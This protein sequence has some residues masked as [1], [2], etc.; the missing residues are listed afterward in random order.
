VLKS[1]GKLLLTFPY[2]KFENHGFFQQFDREMLDRVLELF[3]KQGTY[4]LT[5][6]RYLNGGWNFCEQE[7]CADIVSFNPHTGRGKLDDGAAH[8]RSVCCI[9]F[10]KG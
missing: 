9:E 8:C 4:E 2:G 10:T 7:D 1:D 6:F 3:R 5:F